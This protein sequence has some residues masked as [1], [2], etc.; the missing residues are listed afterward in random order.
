MQTFFFHFPHTL[1]PVDWQKIKLRQISV[2]KI[3]HNNPYSVNKTNDLIKQ[4]H[5]NIG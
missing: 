1:E 3:S 5:N 2:N 4:I